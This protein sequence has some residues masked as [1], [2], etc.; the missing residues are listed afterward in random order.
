MGWDGMGWAGLGWAGMGWDGMG[1]GGIPRAPLKNG[2]P[3]AARLAEPPELHASPLP[4]YPAALQL[5]PPVPP[6]LI[7]RIS[8]IPRIPRIPLG[9]RWSDTGS[10][11][12]RAPDVRDVAQMSKRSGWDG[13]A[14]WICTRPQEALCSCH[15]DEIVPTFAYHAAHPAVHAF[16]SGF[17]HVRIEDPSVHVRIQDPSPPYSTHSSRIWQ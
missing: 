13:G 14:P 17:H 6:I 3:T 12:P 8:R 7:P 16:E 5:A 11:P 4:L 9:T 2:T 10:N 15:H 1:W